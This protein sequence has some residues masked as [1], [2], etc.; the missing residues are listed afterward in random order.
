MY[1]DLY[2]RKKLLGKEFRNLFNNMKDDDDLENK[3]K[4]A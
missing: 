1:F 3:N 2:L 4:S